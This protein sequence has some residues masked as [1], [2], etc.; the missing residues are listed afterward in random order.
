MTRSPVTG[1]SVLGA[2]LLVYAATSFVHFAHNAEFL[3]SYPNLPESWSRTG[4]Y[5]AWLGMTAVG[6]A[7][8][9]L[10]KRGYRKAGLAIVAVYALAGLDSLGHYLVAPPSAHTFGMNATIIP[11]VTAAFAVL[12]LAVHEIAGLSDRSVD[13]GKRP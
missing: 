5:S 12:S 10:E 3:Q 8:W 4:V 11:E 7:G 6:L 9:A 2:L 13:R 1:G